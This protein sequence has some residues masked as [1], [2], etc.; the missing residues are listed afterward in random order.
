MKVLKY[1]YLF[2][3]FTVFVANG[4]SA[5]NKIK[6]NNSSITHQK[7]NKVYTTF[8]KDKK[9][10]N[11]LILA[12][13]KEYEYL[14]LLKDNRVGVITNQTGMYKNKHLVDF[15][16]SK[17]INVKK[18]FS[19]EHGF[20]GKSD[21]GEKVKDGIDTKTGLPI[22]SLY[23]K[24]KKPTSSQ[25]AELD[26]LIFDIQDVG[27]RFYT[28]IS[29]LHYIMEAAA[30]QNKKL[31]ILDRPNPN[32]QYIDGPIL[33]KGNESFIGLHPVPIVYGMTIGEYA[34]MIN[35][36]EW[37]KNKVKANLKVIKMDNYTHDTFYNLP[38]KP[39]PNLPN[40]QSIYLYPSLCFF[41]GTT[42]SV[43]RGTNYPFQVYGA[44]YLDDD[45]QFIPQP[46][47]GAKQP[48]NKGKINKGKDLRNYPRMNK[49]NLSW[50][51]DAR[52]QNRPSPDLFWLKNNFIN[53]LAGTKKLKQQIDQ[54]MNEDEIRK[55]WQPGLEKFKTTRT[56]YLLY[57]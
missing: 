38:I 8:N 47:E 57:P 52:N 46:N 50:L 11:N 45:F 14:P 31:I 34:Q 26:V 18:I 33:E 40:A 9:V 39:S 15:L 51:I 32:S 28:Y 4:C 30:E 49:I 22:I 35:G 19:P 2:L 42:V 27:V 1:T 29:T 13:E 12:I 17:E 48:K 5:Q 43:G 44:P 36:E 6:L 56:K 20:R 3:L 41:E 7:N 37:L 54:G 53:L 25:F 23:G 55:T 21:A 24:N 10:D 16:I